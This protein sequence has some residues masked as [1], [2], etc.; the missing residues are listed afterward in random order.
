MLRRG[1]ITSKLDITRR[2]RVGLLRLTSLPVDQRK[3]E[4]WEVDTQKSKH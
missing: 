3:L 4:C 2:R 1:W